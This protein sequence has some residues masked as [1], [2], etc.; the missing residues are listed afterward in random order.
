M[1]GL[2]VGPS[3]EKHIDTQRADVRTDFPDAHDASHGGMIKVLGVAAVAT[4]A[5]ETTTAALPGPTVTGE[6]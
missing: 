5:S 1:I 2:L 3:V 4:P 6:R